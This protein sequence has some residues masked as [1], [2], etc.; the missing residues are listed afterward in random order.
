ME[1][2]QTDDEILNAIG[3]DDYRIVQKIT[4]KQQ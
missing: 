3:E 2:E 1:I 4:E